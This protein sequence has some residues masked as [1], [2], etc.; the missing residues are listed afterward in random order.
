MLLVCWSVSV[1]L[2]P[3][4]D[5]SFPSTCIYRTLFSRPNVRLLP[6]PPP[7]P[8]L[9]DTPDTHKQEH[10]DDSSFSLLPSGT[11]YRNT[12]GD[13]SLPRT[14][15]NYVCECFTVAQKQQLRSRWKQF[16]LVTTAITK[17][18]T[19]G[20]DVATLLDES[21][22]HPARDTKEGRDGGRHKREGGEG[23]EESWDGG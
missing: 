10:A 6:A 3:P 7:S 8:T 13:P 19:A 5:P 14:F 22:G 21:R 15:H 12:L 9:A 23:G 11:H 1:S 16:I 4:F 18:A 20:R 17:R 2:F